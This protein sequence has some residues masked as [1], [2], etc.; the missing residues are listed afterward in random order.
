MLFTA[1]HDTT[2]AATLF[3]IYE[4]AINQVISVAAATH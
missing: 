2:T 3:C 4:L 1:G